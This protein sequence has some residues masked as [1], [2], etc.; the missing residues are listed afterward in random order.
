M[1]RA[2]RVSVLLPVRDA[3]TTLPECFASLSAQ[4][5]GDFELL[6]VDD[7]S[8]DGSGAL[9]EAAARH[10]RRVRV[11]RRAEAWWRP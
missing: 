10:D 9:L 4:S 11:P 8:T 5:L 6:V 3:V 1:T 2:P 7:A